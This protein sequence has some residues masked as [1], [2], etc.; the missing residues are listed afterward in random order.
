M[1]TGQNNLKWLSSGNAPPLGYVP[2]RLCM[3]QQLSGR[4]GLKNKRQINLIALWDPDWSSRGGCNERCQEPP[5]VTEVPDCTLL[6][7]GKAT[8]SWRLQGGAVASAR[9]GGGCGVSRSSASRV[10]RVVARCLMTPTP[11]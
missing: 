7:Q 4:D 10:A 11:S 6:R 2:Q 9:H 3:A 8:F 1:T 5:P